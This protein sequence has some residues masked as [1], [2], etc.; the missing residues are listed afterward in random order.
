MYDCSKRLVLFV[1]LMELKDL[2]SIMSGLN[3]GCCSDEVLELISLNFSL[4]L[5]EL[6]SL[7]FVGGELLSNR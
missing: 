2:G 7:V 1:P 3:L 6:L 4:L 5:L